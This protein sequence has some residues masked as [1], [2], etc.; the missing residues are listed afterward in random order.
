MTPSRHQ[1]TP[2]DIARLCL[3]LAQR[4]LTAGLRMLPRVYVLGATKAGSTTLAAALWSHPAHLRPFA[5]ELWYLNDL[6]GFTAAWRFNPLVALLWAGHYRGR[7]HVSDAGYRKFFPIRGTAAEHSFTSDCD[8]FNLY[9]PVAMARIRRLCPDARFVIS[10][11]DPVDRA[12]SDYNMHRNLDPEHT[13][14]TFEKAIDAELSAGAR[15]PFRK[16]FLAQG[17]Y[18]PHLRRWLS[19]LPSDRFL[20]LNAADLRARTA[21]VG[22]EILRFLDLPEAPLATAPQNVGRYR[23]ELAPETRSRLARYFKP[24]NQRLFEL[25][26]RDLGWNA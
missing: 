15:L 4:R 10:L 17:I 3:D 6:P 18:E 13:P 12:F 26:G 25:L 8:P 16:R 7:T 9:C 21:D 24:H 20:L 1:G 23:V 2:T 19:A 11:R 22:R 5:K 14:D